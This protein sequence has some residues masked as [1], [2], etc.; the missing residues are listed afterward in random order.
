MKDIVSEFLDRSSHKLSEFI[1][2][3]DKWEAIA[4]LVSVLKIL[5]DATTFFST[6]SPSVA[7][8]IPAMDAIDEAFASGIVQCETLSAPVCHALSIGKRTL[9][10]YYQL[11]DDSYVYR[12]AIVLHPSRKVDYL[13]KAGWQEAWID[14]A[15]AVTRENW[16]RTFSP[17]QHTTSSSENTPEV[18]LDHLVRLCL[19]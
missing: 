8:V 11:T 4:G 10:K 9:N 3:D 14:K 18:S 16:E 5:K 13:R 6:D 12:M 2:D 17:A 1:L 19:V 15:V 7:A